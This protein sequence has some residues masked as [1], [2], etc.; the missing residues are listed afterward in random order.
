VSKIVGVQFRK[1]GKVYDFDCGHFVLKKG[2]K[3]IVVSEEGP[4]VGFVCTDPQTSK[5][6]ETARE[7][8][9]IFRLATDE[10][11]ERFEKNCSE[12]K[13]VYKYCCTKMV[14][15]SLPM[16]L[17]AV[18]RRFDGSKFI[19][20]F[21][22][23]GRVDFR[24]LVKDLVRKFRSRIEMRQIGVRHEA[25]MLGGLG[26]CGRTL[27]CST[28]LNNFAPVTIKMAKEQNISLNPGKISGMCGRLMCCLTYEHSYYEKVKK[29]LPKVGKTVA[30][31]SGEGKVIRQNVLNESLSVVLESGEEIEVKSKD[32]I[33]DRL[34]RKKSRKGRKRQKSDQ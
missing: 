3:V 19:V 17:V 21:T 20:Y 10:E 1:N 16:R 33:K 31:P 28:F 23:D 2:D 4:S 26:S 32:L 12:E 34:F 22:A 30:L 25:K 8:K 24:Q 6:K 13:E 27:C 7:L 14:E 9:K 5:E 15:R 29:E 18:E 11:I